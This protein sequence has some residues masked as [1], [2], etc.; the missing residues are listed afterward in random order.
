MN[1]GNSALII[2]TRITITTTKKATSTDKRSKKYL[3]QDGTTPRER[4]FRR[5]NVDFKVFYK[6]NIKH[7]KC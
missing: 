6:K 4:F 2:L 1:T 5:D 7:V 3:N